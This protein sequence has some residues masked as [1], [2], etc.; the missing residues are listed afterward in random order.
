MTNSIA[1]VF[2]ANVIFVIGSNTTENHPVIG[3]KIKQA[4]KNGAKLI[5]ADAREIELAS[6]ADI[7]LKL[8]P[9]TNI[10]L[11]NGMMNVIISEN[12]C[13]LEYIEKHTEGFETLKENI[14]RF[15][16]QMAAEICGIDVELLKEAARLYASADK[17][18]IYYAM[19]IT[20]FKT[21][22]SGV[23]S[24]SNLAMITGN[25]GKEGAGINPLRGQNNVQGACDMGCLPEYY[26]GYLYTDDNKGIERFEKLWN[27]ELSHKRGLTVPHIL[28]GLHN[29]EIKFMYIFGEN[30]I[31]S[32]PDTNHVKECF[33]NAEFVVCQDI[34]FNETC[35]YADVVLPA[36]AFAEKNG[37]FTNT[38]RRVQR[39]RA[40]LPLKGQCKP[41]WLIF[42]E[43]MER[44]G[45]KGFESEEAIFNEIRQA[46][47]NYAGITYERIENQ[48]IQWPCKSLD[49]PG[50]KFMHKDGPVR[51]KGILAYQNYEE[52]AEVT[53]E[54]YPFILTTGRNLYHYHTRTM[55][56]RVNG[57]D[58]ISNESY[59]EI[60]PNR[61]EELGIKDGDKVLVSS[62]RGTVE[63]FAKV[64]DK[65]LE[66]VVFMTFHFAQGN[67]NVLTNT[68]LD[69]ECE[70]SELKVCAVNV[71]KA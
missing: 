37:T 31:V 68:A 6:K 55:T 58:E 64:T 18:A 65:I 39:V 15:T 44:L 26:P 45:H 14:L 20:Q 30:P 71:K 4:V 17:S 38:E 8:K 33:E 61:A 43:L 25:L 12:L 28:K 21:G 1:E 2:S 66:E 56:G 51:G 49:D 67:C 70:I 36:A 11:L 53:S 27:M 40:A 34:F 46:I 22:T 50:T 62:R 35:E 32:D 41:D 13:D 47:P 16:P 24:V 19:G 69:P 54:E 29:K 23:M 57:L 3:S 52:A 5:V 42:S 48:G 63:T 10:A 59:V 7:Y 60:H 9:G